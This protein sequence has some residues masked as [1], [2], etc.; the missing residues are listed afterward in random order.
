MSPFA[1]HGPA[2]ARLTLVW[3]AGTARRGPTAN[4]KQLERK[5]FGL[6]DKAV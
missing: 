4:L 2:S 1:G 3:I 6:V 5:R